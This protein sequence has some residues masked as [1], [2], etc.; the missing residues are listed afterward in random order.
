MAKVFCPYLTQAP[1]EFNLDKLSFACLLEYSETF[2]GLSNV[3]QL[4]LRPRI[5]W[6]DDFIYNRGWQRW[7]GEESNLVGG[8]LETA[9]VYH[10]LLVANSLDSVVLCLTFPI[11]ISSF[12][13]F[14]I[15]SIE[16]HF[17]PDQHGFNQ[18]AVSKRANIR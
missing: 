4:A 16:R 18:F 14:Y 15:S 13:N 6:D 9:A 3:K 2:K 5:V 17:R 8:S 12:L 10:F 7:R 1:I 11:L